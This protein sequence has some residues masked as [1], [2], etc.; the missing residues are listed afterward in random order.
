MSR[1]GVCECQIRSCRFDWTGSSYLGVC[2]CEWACVYEIQRGK[3]REGGLDE[4][5]ECISESDKFKSHDVLKLGAEKKGWR[6]RNKTTALNKETWFRLIP[7]NTHMLTAAFLFLY[8]NSRSAVTVFYIE[9]LPCVREMCTHLY[10]RVKKETLIM[11]KEAHPPSP[12]D[13]LSAHV[14]GRTH[15]EAHTQTQRHSQ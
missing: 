8:I 14:C 4:E 7:P 13:L 5:W 2:L 11:D 3:E 10:S 15:S 9:L 1:R 6:E 12:L